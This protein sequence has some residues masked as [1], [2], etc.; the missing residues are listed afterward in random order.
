MTIKPGK[1]KHFKGNQY[2]VIGTATHS[3]TLEEMVL[4]RP[5]DGNGTLWVR[6]QS[7]WDEIVEHNGQLVKRF[8]YEE[9]SD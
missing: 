9:A 3:E 6:P 4:Y 1:Y 5:L 8:T 7:M 2:E